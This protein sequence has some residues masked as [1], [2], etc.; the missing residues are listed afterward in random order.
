MGTKRRKI[1]EVLKPKQATFRQNLKA[2]E[3]E[4]TEREKTESSDIQ[5]VP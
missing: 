3:R 1:T 5:T 4:K 2:W